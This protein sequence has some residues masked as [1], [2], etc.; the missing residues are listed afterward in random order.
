ML[1]SDYATRLLPFPTFILSMRLSN[2]LYRSESLLF[3]EFMNNVLIP[4]LI[5]VSYCMFCFRY[6]QCSE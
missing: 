3:S 1:K 5:S 2:T 4:I 6:S